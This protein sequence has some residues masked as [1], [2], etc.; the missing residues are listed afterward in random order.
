MQYGVAKGI[1]RNRSPRLGLPDAAQ[2]LAAIGAGAIA[3]LGLA[4]WILPAGQLAWVHLAP[5]HAIAGIASAGSLVFSFRPKERGTRMPMRVLAV[6][7]VLPALASIALSISGRSGALLSTG[8]GPPT[9]AA[10]AFLFLGALLYCVDS[11]SGPAAAIADASVLG[12]GW[13]ILTLVAEWLFRAMHVFELEQS[14]P[15]SQALL[16]MLVLLA[17]TAVARRLENGMF[18]VFLGDGM[19]SRITRTLLPIVLFLPFFREVLRARLIAS[20]K[21]PEHVATSAMAS[22]AAMV[23][24]GVLLVIGYYFRR[25]ENEIR[26]L[27]LRDELTGL[28]NLRGF[29]LLADQAFRLAQRSHL[30]FSVMFVDVD[31]LK[32]I[33][34]E[35]GHAAGSTLLAETAELLRS[36]FRETDVVG[37]IGGDEFAIAGQFDSES[38]A[39]AAA[40]LVEAAGRTGSR[41]HPSLS[42][43]YVSADPHGHE[44]LKNLLALADAA[45]Y[46]QKRRKKQSQMTI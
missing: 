15:A 20:G 2:K 45:M 36:K 41:L 12:L 7:A 40:R 1:W 9:L 16:W 8:A 24:V 30:P 38:I 39:E 32:L 10:V 27:S 42:I 33:N 21:V 31:D 29:Q 35:M 11:Q 4:A 28:Y 18:A 17:A 46:D 26:E 43:G 6:A 22:T 3:C 25:M 19:S 5:L 14:T 44:T 34:D 37:R 13:S 23:S